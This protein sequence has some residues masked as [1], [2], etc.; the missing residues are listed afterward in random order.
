MGNRVLSRDM[1][2][3]SILRSVWEGTWASS[4]R[5][6][7]LIS[8]NASW[9]I[10]WPISVVYHLVTML[11]NTVHTAFR[12]RLRIEGP[13][14]TPT[15]ATI[16][17][18]LQLHPA[19]SIS[20][21]HHTKFNA[22]A[23]SFWHSPIRLGN[24]DRMK[25]II[26]IPSLRTAGVVFSVLKTIPKSTRCTTQGSFIGRRQLEQPPTHLPPPRG[27]SVSNADARQDKVAT[28]SK[29]REPRLWFVFFLS[30][31]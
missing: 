12:P 27:W 13:P 23:F 19:P 28:S 17:A 22:V 3:T 1:I 21:A 4:K 7:K 20:L 24:Y 18:Y 30:A 25:K 31:S 14:E 5:I 29:G 10:S 11:W 6:Q 15:C 8:C 26:G 9:S 2:S 16:G